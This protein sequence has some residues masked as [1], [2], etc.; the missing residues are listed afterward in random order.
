MEKVLTC[1]YVSNDIKMDENTNILLITGPNM[2]GKSTYMRQ[3]AITV[4]MAQIGCFVPASEAEM[5][6]FDAIYTRIGASDDLV[7]GESTFMVE[8]NEANNA[9]SNA[10]SNSLILFD[11]LGRGTATFDGMA[12][13]QAIIEYI[14]NFV[15]CKMIFSTH[16]HELTDLEDSLSNLKNV[17][18]SAYEENGNITFLHKIKEG[19][20]DKSY[21]IHV[22]KLANLPSSLIDR[23]NVI[24]D[25]YENKEVK[26]DIKIQESL[27][28]VFESNTSKVEEML[29]N[30]DLLST[31]PIEALNILY[32]LKEEMKK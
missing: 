10:T 12:L 16:Y 13:A 32:K 25:I 24:L 8:M 4:I 3:L 22:A 14:H 9:I 31:T 29:D 20:V 18:V 26:R 7:S 30:V 21:G 17:H 23:A 2:A 15:K 28:L 1:E 11:E 5:M 19:S 6:V 27:P